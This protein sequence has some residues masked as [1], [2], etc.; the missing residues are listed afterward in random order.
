MCNPTIHNWIVNFQ[1]F[2]GH[3]VQYA[4]INEMLFLHRPS[5]YQTKNSF[6]RVD[7]MLMDTEDVSSPI[8]YLSQQ[9]TQLDGSNTFD[10]LTISR[11]LGATVLGRERRHGHLVPRIDV[12]GSIVVH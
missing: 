1:G 8:D 3:S 6:K 5:V 12:L 4:I 9:I 7:N 2:F 11:L 10:K